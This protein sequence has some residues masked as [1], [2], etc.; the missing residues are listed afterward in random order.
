MNPNVNGTQQLLDADLDGLE[1]GDL[2]FE[3]VEISTPLGVP[4]S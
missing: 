1:L 4:P 3:A 2:D